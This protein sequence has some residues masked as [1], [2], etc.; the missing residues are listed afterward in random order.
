AL[1][2]YTFGDMDMDPGATASSGLVIAYASDNPA[3]AT[4]VDGKIQITGAGTATI[5]A[6]QADNAEYLP[7]PDVTSTLTVERRP[8]TIGFAADAAV[9]KEYDGTTRAEVT[10]GQLLFMVGDVLADDEVRIGL[11][12]AS[13]TYDTEEAG[14]DKLVTLP[15]ANVSLAGADAKNY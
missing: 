7:A 1:A 11:A 12:T 4:I 6:S 8:V 13:A 15:L 14:T 2:P 3:V 5:T 9:S 10:V